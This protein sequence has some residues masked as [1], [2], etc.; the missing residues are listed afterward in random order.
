MLPGYFLVEGK[1]QKNT[2]GRRVKIHEG[3]E[4]KE[5]VLF[6]RETS[7]LQSVVSKNG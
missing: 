4:K 3:H 1:N 5:Y 2:W 7:F 6:E